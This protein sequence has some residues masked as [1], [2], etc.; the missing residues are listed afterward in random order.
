MSGAN[1]NNQSRRL[2]LIERQ[3]QYAEKRKSLQF[4]DKIPQ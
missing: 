3:T 4:L 2:S 1:K